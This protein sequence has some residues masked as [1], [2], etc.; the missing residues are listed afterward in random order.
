[1]PHRDVLAVVTGSSVS[2]E[3]LFE[4]AARVLR[5]VGVEAGQ[6]CLDFGCGHG[7]Y[8][9]P[10]AWLAGPTGKVF[11][12]DKDKGALNKLARRARA[13]GLANIK[14]MPSSGELT[15]PL[16]DGS[17][18]VTLL[19]DVLHAHYFSAGQ[20]AS[21]LE[22][23]ARVSK[24]RALLS[25]FPNHM[26]DNEVDREVV[27]RA[28]ALGFESASEYEGLLV[29]DDGVTEGRILTFRKVDA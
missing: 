28:G 10:L 29:H 14:R 5:A 7:N 6:T 4:T 23:V 13:A 25:V 1:M 8:T 3:R 20:R 24:P 2:T 18:D 27:A 21:L 15:L 11:A 12:V 26:T 22:E 9:V 16:E 17:V 19:Y